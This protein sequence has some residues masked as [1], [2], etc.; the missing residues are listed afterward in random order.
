MLLGKKKTVRWRITA[1]VVATA[2]VTLAGVLLARLGAL[3]GLWDWPPRPSSGFGVFCGIAGGAIVLF[4]MALVLRKRMRKWRLGRTRAWM[5]L[6]IWLG[7]V[8][9][10]VILVHAGF[11][12]GGPLATVTLVLFL[13]VTFSGVWG[14]IMQQ[15]IPQKMLADIPGETITSQ[16]DRLGEYNAD[17]ARR[18]VI[19]LTTVPPE[20]ESGEPVIGGPL[21]VELEAFRDAVLLPYLQQGRD[22]RSPLTAATEAERQFARL[23]EAV[24][25]EARTDLDRL[26]ALADLRRRWDYQARLYFWLHNWLLVHLP[27]SAAMTA[28]MIW[29]AVRA[30]K[31]W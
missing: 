6:H 28:L 12:F 15:W 2:G 25:P 17:E 11:G 24:P 7:L 14:L 22:S 21:K 4:E 27:L 26:Q 5:R 29:H 19:G 16:I 23:R 9:L 31:Y 1:I 20:A 13:L 3:V 8:C 10:P 18:V 30:L